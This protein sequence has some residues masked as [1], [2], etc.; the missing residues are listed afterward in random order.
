MWVRIIAASPF[1]SCA[2]NGLEIF[3]K[4]SPHKAQ[5]MMDGGALERFHDSLTYVH[6]KYKLNLQ[7]PVAVNFD[8]IQIC[9]GREQTL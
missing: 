3:S 9:L 6:Q 7:L 4:C 2:N 8:L 5:G 1:S